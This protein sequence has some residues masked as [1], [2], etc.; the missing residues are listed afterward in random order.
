MGMPLYAG[1][2][3]APFMERAGNVLGS[4]GDKMGGMDA[5]KAMRM[6]NMSGQ[7]QQQ[8]ARPAAMQRPQSQPAT[9]IESPYS[10]PI[11]GGVQLTEEQKA[12]LRQRLGGQY[13]GLIG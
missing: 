4:M 2:P 11:S 5:S 12:L 9:Q 10:Q 8:V 7:P 1:S 3:D 13:G 6:M